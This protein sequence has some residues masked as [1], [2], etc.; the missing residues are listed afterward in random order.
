M[1]ITKTQLRKIIKEESAKVLS[2]YYPGID[3]DMADLKNKEREASRKAQQASYARQDQSKIEDQGLKDGKNS[4]N[5]PVQSDNESYMKGYLKGR[6]RRLET[7]ISQDERNKKPYARFDTKSIAAMVPGTKTNKKAR[8]L[9]DNISNAKKE[10][11]AMK[12]GSWMERY[13]K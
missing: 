11:K 5:P 1:K 9:L 13:N 3:N 6:R 12:D 7:I 4:D 2:E 10:L 8:D